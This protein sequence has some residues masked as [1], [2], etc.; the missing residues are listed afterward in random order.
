MRGAVHELPI[1]SERH[2]VHRWAG[3]SKHGAPTLSPVARL[4]LSTDL[5][6]SDSD[7]LARILVQLRIV[8]TQHAARLRADGAPP[9]EMVVRVKELMK[10]AL[11]DEGWWD[12]EAARSLTAAMV[13]WGID[14]YYGR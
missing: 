1:A 10:R 7:F 8:A 14:A 9:E 3:A 4:G 13:V 5:E 2:E 6:T 12:R 11:D